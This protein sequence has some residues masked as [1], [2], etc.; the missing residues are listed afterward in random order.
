MDVE[1]DTDISIKECQSEY[2]PP[3]SEIQ[4][5]FLISS[6]DVRPKVG[7]E[8]EKLNSFGSISERVPYRTVP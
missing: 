1:V 3:A 4:L 2:L 5:K 7:G 6:G 8:T